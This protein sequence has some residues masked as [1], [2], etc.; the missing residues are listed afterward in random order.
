MPLG[1]VSGVGQ[2]IGVIDGDRQRGRSSFGVNLGRPIVT[3][4]ELLHSCVEV[5][6]LNRSS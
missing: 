6:K 2:G 4:G 3:N 1:M 5:G